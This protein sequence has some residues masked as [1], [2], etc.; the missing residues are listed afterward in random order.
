MTIRL[1]AQYTSKIEYKFF[2]TKHSQVDAA[3]FK[4]EEGSNR[5]IIVTGNGSASTSS[6]DSTTQKASSDSQPSTP[7]SGNCS[8]YRSIDCAAKAQQISIN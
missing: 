4:W 2:E 1:P 5:A 8:L 3:D 6:D 7:T